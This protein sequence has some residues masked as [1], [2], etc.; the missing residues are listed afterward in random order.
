MPNIMADITICAP[1]NECTQ[2]SYLMP[3]LY[4]CTKLR[5]IV[6][7]STATADTLIF[8]NNFLGLTVT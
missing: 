8:T 1:K 5:N 2:W 7:L 4:L 3:W 6:T